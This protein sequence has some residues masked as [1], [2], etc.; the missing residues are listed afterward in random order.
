MQTPS[1]GKLA[2][3]ALSLLV[4]I[5]A[6]LVRRR[7]ALPAAGEAGYAPAKKKRRLFMMLGVLGLWLFSGLVLGLFRVERE[8]LEVTISPARV[9]L[10][11]ISTS[12]SVIVAWIVIA[13]LAVFAILVR[14]LA[15]PRFQETPRGLQLVLETAVGAVSDFTKGK[16]G[17]RRNEALAAYF[18]ALAALFVGS[19]FVE[20][21]G[22]RPPTTDL[23]MTLSYALI[24]FILINYTGIRK[25]GVRGHLAN[26]AKPN[27]L[28]TPFKFLSEIAIPISLAC[29]LFGNML[30]GMI[31]V[32]LVYMALG[33]FSV[34]IPAVLGLYFNAFHP[35]IQFFIFINLSLTFIG[36]AAE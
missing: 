1:A 27:A 26:F 8:T 30:G 18:F 32:D 31:V 3:I 17:G 14:V 19:A 15:I 25:K 21:L 6:L 29:R 20:L 35:L 11:G 24:T 2:A 7:V 12:T 34:G 28:V 33:A 22:L 16:F 10:L 23:T 13:A 4:G 36:E 9:E 5:L